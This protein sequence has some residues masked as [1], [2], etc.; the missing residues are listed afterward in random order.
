MYN[1][2]SQFMVTK[3][4]IVTMNREL[5][6]NFVND[7]SADVLT[8]NQVGTDLEAIVD[9]AVRLGDSIYSAIQIAI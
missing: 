3:R 2:I 1:Y 9:V 6:T 5:A 4:R 7:G 8:Q